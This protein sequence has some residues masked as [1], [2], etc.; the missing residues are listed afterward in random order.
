MAF[1]DPFDPAA[2]NIQGNPIFSQPDEVLTYDPR[3]LPCTN[4]FVPHFGIYDPPYALT[5][6]SAPLVTSDQPLPTSPPATPQSGIPTPPSPTGPVMLHT[7]PQDPSPVKFTLATTPQDKPA[8]TVIAAPPQGDLGASSKNNQSG[9]PK[10]VV[11]PGQSP[12]A[13][14]PEP[15][16]PPPRWSSSASRSATC[17]NRDPACP[18]SSERGYSCW[19][20]DHG[21]WSSR[22]CWRYT[23]QSVKRFRCR[24][25]N[26]HSSPGCPGPNLPTVAGNPIATVAGG[27][28][29]VGSNT[30]TAG[31]VAATFGGTGISVLP[32]GGVVIVGSST[33]ALPVAPRPPLPT[34]AGQPIQT[35]PNGAVVIGGNTVT[36]GGAPITVGGTTFSVP[37][38]GGGIIV[39]GNT[40]TVPPTPAAS[41]PTVGG[42]QVQAGPNGAV[43][44][45]TDVIFA[46]GSAATISGTV[47]SAL[48]GGSS[49]IVNGNT[50]PLALAPA[51][52][53]PPVVAGQ[54]VQTGPNGAVVVGGTTLSAGGPAATISGT[55]ISV[56]PSGGGLVAGG[57]STILL[58]GSI[59][60]AVN[61][62]S[63]IIVFGAPAKTIS[64]V[65]VSLGTS[66]L[67]IGSTSVPITTG[68]VGNLGG[69]IFSA[70]GGSPGASPTGGK[71]NST[72][73]DTK[74]ATP[75]R[76]SSTGSQIPTV[77]SATTSGP[78]SVRPSATGNADRTKDDV[79]LGIH[80]LL[81]L[82][83][84]WILA[85]T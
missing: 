2:F 69:I 17:H 36:P 58:P 24:R 59:P 30:I 75:G 83:V 29:V 31:G 56:L 61:I 4:L 74:T 25:W 53:P 39:N 76:T 80:A 3:W 78:A 8:P 5:K 84:L 27:G 60:T 71:S 66:G 7:V 79:W 46:G 15:S 19:H 41:S 40:M 33:V 12:E 37:V 65:L 77:G 54:T 28:I 81:L 64:G 23:C 52:T 6:A 73:L 51:A 82:G 42:Q 10:T 43:V 72:V 11:A 16:P 45:G 85:L 48:T 47:I 13:G 68:E 50:I 62:G 63:N 1:G 34:L 57:S 22:H 21:S 70:F 38:N 49:I 67:E 18:A 9:D 44:I 32:G 26:Y 35:A 20:D 14:S 55:V